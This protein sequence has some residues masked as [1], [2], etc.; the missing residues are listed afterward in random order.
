[1]VP[2]GPA[3][4]FIPGESEAVFARG[5]V[6]VG[7]AVSLSLANLGPKF[8]RGKVMSYTCSF[9]PL[10]PRSIPIRNPSFPL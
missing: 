10:P 8:A 1:M 2:V 4:Q 7:P 6:L 3:S 9:D 5:K